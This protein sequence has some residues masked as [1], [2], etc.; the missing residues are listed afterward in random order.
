VGYLLLY[1]DLQGPSAVT[2][3]VISEGE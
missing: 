1:N 3:C 2:R